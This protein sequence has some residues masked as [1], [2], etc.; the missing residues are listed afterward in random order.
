MNDAAKFLRYWNATFLGNKLSR[1]ATSKTWV[2]FPSNFLCGLD[3]GILLS[4]YF[5]SY[6]VMVAL[7]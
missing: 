3:L 6:K 1:L 2:Q 4:H 5:S 7:N